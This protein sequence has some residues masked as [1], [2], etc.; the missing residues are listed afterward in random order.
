MAA[1]PPVELTAKYNAQLYRYKCDDSARTWVEDPLDVG[2]LASEALDIT[3]SIFGDVLFI[4]DDKLHYYTS[5][6]GYNA[7][8]YPKQS[9]NVDF[10]SVSSSFLPAADTAKQQLDSV[11][12]GAGS[13]HGPLSPR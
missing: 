11:P 6:R 5:S 2:T 12:T 4:C 13:S 7:N 3:V 10:L 8:S 1:I 9:A